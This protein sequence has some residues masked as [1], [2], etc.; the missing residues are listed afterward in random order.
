MVSFI[1]KRSI[2]FGNFDTEGR[3]E[4]CKCRCHQNNL[5]SEKIAN[6]PGHH[7]IVISKK[8]EQDFVTALP[9]T[10]NPDQINRNKGEPINSNDIEPFSKSQKIFEAKKLSLVLCN[11]PCRIPREFLKEDRDEGRLKE[12]RYN[13]ILWT[14]KGC[15]DAGDF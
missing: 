2:W 7:F 15:I 3:K 4:A 5:P 11:K 14:V 10:S 1:P 9:I 8:N 12:T 6:N 13:D